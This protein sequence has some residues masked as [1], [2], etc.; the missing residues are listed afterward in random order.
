MGKENLQ[1]PLCFPL[2]FGKSERDSLRFA[3]A[4]LRE[5]VTGTYLPLAAGVW[6][7]C[8]WARKKEDAPLF[9]SYLPN[10]QK[11]AL[12]G[13]LKVIGRVPEK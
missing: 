2:F 10:S 7:C 4:G 13:I 1:N 12:I 6:R 9:L 8:E 11:V 5:S 3:Q